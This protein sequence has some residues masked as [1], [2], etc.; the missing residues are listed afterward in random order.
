[1]AEI[2]VIITTYNSA[3]FISRAIRSVLN[4]SFQDFEIIIADDA[5]TDNTNEVVNT[6]TKTDPR[7]KVRLVTVE[8]KISPMA[9]AVWPLRIAVKSIAS[10]GKVVPKETKVKPITDSLIFRKRASTIAVSTINF[11]LTITPINPTKSKII[12]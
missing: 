12:E 8:P 9:K 2:S 5:S 7:I 10:S 3:H 1:M 6:F 11:A 4:Q